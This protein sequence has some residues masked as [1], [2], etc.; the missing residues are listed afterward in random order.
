MHPCTKNPRQFATA[1]PRKPT[2]WSSSIHHNGNLTQNVQEFLA[3][4]FFN[5]S[6]G[7]GTALAILIY[8]NSEGNFPFSLHQ[9][10]N[11]KKDLSDVVTKWSTKKQQ[12]G[13][14]LLSLHQ[15]SFI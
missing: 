14:I 10:E 4:L 12:S 2:S 7:L 8:S 5:G 9:K 1:F 15:Y 13:R 11:F 6:R 3:I